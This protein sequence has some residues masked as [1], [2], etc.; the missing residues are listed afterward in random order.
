MIS[1]N[2]E[3][4]I[5]KFS[6]ITSTS[7]GDKRI[8][9][10]AKQA[11]IDNYGLITEDVYFLNVNDGKL[12]S[13]KKLGE[14]GGSIELPS[15]KEKLIALHNHPNSVS[16]SFKDFVT[17]NNNPE[18]KTMIAAGHDGTV[19]ILAVENGE[20]LDLTDKNDFEYY[21]RQWAIAYI[22][23]GGDFGANSKFTEELG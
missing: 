21:Y 19:H 14:Y 15:T 3:D 16:F 20:R 8:A 12:I 11:I 17:V 6:G 2:S 22:E 13:H 23:N 9:E 10:F 4:Y 5:K 7:T 18:I 1:I